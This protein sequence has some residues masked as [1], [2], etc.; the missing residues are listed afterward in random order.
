MTD[1]K[2]TLTEKA[3]LVHFTTKS[4][5]STR[6]DKNISEEV[7]EKYKAE[8]PGRYFK[9]LFRRE[10]IKPIWTAVN[11]S[12]NLCYRY[13][14]PW[15]DGNVRVM[16]VG[17]LEKFLVENG[18]IM[19]EYETA[20]N[21]FIED[22][23]NILDINKRRLNNLFNKDDYPT[24]DQAKESFAIRIGYMPLPDRE[25]FRIAAPEEIVNQMKKKY[26]SNVKES[27][28]RAKS[29]VADRI[30]DTV[31]RLL[32]KLSKEDKPLRETAFSRIEPLVKNLRILNI[33]ED[34]KIETV[35][36]TMEK[37]FASEKA[38]IINENASLRKQKKDEAKA[39][40][41]KVETLRRS[42]VF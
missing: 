28:A 36:K 1:S 14:L 17:L 42:L 3:V 7:E 35:L 21:A 8:T 13:S 27:E 20:V 24:K 16:P 18:K 37:N 33:T 39:V 41:E 15:F 22:Y 4:L 9:R 40:L 26:D 6:I 10:D 29:E 11:K 12:K 23:D 32:D 31:Q 38:D 5:G 19:K 34:A 25:D 2:V 30:Y